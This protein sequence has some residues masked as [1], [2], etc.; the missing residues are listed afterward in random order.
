MNINS[1]SPSFG[2]LQVATSKMNNKQMDLSDKFCDS[3][4]Y[5]DTYQTLED[6]DI[7]V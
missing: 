4:K 6:Q 7:D 2:S 5:D 3:L 1:V